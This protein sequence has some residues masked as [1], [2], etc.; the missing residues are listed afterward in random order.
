MSEDASP[1]P[2]DFRATVADGRL[3]IVR[4]HPHLMLSWGPATA[5]FRAR[6]EAGVGIADLTVIREPECQLEL[7]V[8]FLSG[9]G[10]PNVREAIVRWAS[11]L[12]YGRVWFPEDVVSLEG[13]G[14]SPACAAATRCRSCEACWEDGDPEFWL[15]VRSNGNFPIA[16][17]ICGA[18]LPQWEI[19]PTAD[20]GAP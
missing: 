2:P 10:R 18:D 12:G 9:A 3:T 15:A 20:T 5:H 7:V 16:C 17:P 4:W 6:D 11:C 14:M 8:K 19:Q 1:G 13:A